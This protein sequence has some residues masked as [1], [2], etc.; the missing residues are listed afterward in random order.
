[1]N[2]LRD[3]LNIIASGAAE[4]GQ[5]SYLKEQSDLPQIHYTLEVIRNPNG[6]ISMYE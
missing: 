3:I 5:P 2:S 4:M 6:T 1:M